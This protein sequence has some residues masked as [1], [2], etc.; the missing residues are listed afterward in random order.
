MDILFILD[1]FD[2]LKPQKETSIAMMRAAEAAGHRVVGCLQGDISLD[3]GKVVAR[4]TP[5]VTTG[6]DKPWYRAAEPFTAP[7]ST[8]D[9]V[10]MRKDP[11][12]DMEYV[13]STYMLERAVEQGARVYNN[14]AAIRDHNEKFSIWSRVIRRCCANSW[15]AMAR[16][17]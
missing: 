14:P 12:F 4:M 17:C 2:S 15:P 13:Y 16:R 9:A 3:Q 10:I 5:L 1:P 7:L 11:P 6:Q 8:V